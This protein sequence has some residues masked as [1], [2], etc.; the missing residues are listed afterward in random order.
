M[1]RMGWMASAGCLWMAIAGMIQAQDLRTK[2][3]P[4][5]ANLSASPNS[6][7]NANA[8]PNAPPNAAGSAQALMNML[9]SL[10]PY[11]PSAPLSA[12]I[13]VYGSTAMDNMAHAWAEEFN[14]FHPKVAVEVS[15]A[16][17]GDAF[18]Q[19]KQNPRS[20]VMLSRPVKKE[21]LEQIKSATITKPVAFVVA[22][23]A[24]GVFV[25][26]TNPVK[27]ISGEQM[28]A[29]FTKQLADADLK[30]K[31]LGVSGEMAEQPIRIVSRSETSGTQAFLREFV[32]GGMEMRTSSTTHGSNGDVLGAL[33]ADPLGITICGLRANGHG[34]RTV[35]LVSR[36]VIVPSDDATVLSGHYPL[37]RDLTLVLD[38]GQTTP[39]A[40]AAQEFVHFA[41]CRSGQLAAI[42]SGF[43]PAELPSLR[44]GLSLLDRDKLR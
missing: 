44:S 20:L 5:S 11:R 18:G 33:A 19:L 7:A 31:L 35:P 26:A 34:V 12:K 14:L 15:A 37:T 36:G 22:R 29:V 30:W 39:E 4:A 8:N 21:E 2:A 17:S 32:F 38:L 25:H 27:A 16:G 6:N 13:Q 9:G 23:E 3:P 41:L 24:L 1:L 10:D 28:R 43:F 40:K 42:K